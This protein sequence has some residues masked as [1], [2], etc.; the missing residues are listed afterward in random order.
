MNVILVHSL[1][2]EWNEQEMCNFFWS[3]IVCGYAL[4]VLFYVL[5]L[6]TCN[7]TIYGALFR[8]WPCPRAGWLVYR[9]RFRVSLSPHCLF[10]NIPKC[11]KCSTVHYHR[12]QTKSLKFNYFSTKWLCQWILLWQYK[13]VE[14]VFL[15]PYSSPFFNFATAS[16]WYK[17]GISSVSFWNS[18]EA[19]SDFHPPYNC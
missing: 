13:I 18:C 5:L 4:F 12:D 11:G 3:F 10:G 17:F 7:Q 14:A 8:C 15:C 1:T 9:R 16:N 6:L 19:A 2:F